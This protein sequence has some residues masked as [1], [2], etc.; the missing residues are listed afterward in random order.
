MTF[1]SFRLLDLKSAQ[2]PNHVTQSN[3]TKF[4]VNI[5]LRAQLSSAVVLR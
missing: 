3:E 2:M 5:F 1:K 4:G